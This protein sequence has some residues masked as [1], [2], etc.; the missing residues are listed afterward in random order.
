MTNG[1]SRGDESLLICDWLMSLLKEDSRVQADTVF[2]GTAPSE[3]SSFSDLC[4][5]F[6]VY[7]GAAAEDVLDDLTSA[8]RE[9]TGVLH[10]FDI[11][12]D[13][14]VCRLLLLTGG[15]EA[16]LTALREPA[17]T[18]TETALAIDESSRYSLAQQWFSRSVGLC[19]HHVLRARNAIEKGCYWTAEY[20]ISC[21]R[22]YVMGLACSR[23]A[24]GA[25][26]SRGADALPRDVRETFDQTLVRFV[27]SFEVRRALGVCIWIYLGEVAAIDAALARKLES[28]LARFTL[29]GDATSA[30]S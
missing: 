30:V 8:I 16:N 17:S 12:A 4:L 23:L 9:A 15:L 21:F 13:D 3:E 6:G 27:D 25:I 11:T 26:N 19:W 1:A 29:F 28:A 7:P 22:N 2:G 10:H 20:E 24:P 5:S 14:G 18:G